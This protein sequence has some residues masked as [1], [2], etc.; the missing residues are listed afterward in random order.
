[1]GYKLFR[2]RS[3]QLSGNP[4]AWSELM[5]WAEFHHSSIINATLACYLHKKDTI[6]DITSKYL[7]QL[8]LHYR[9]D[10]SLPI[11][12]KFELRGAH[13]SSKDAPDTAPLYKMVFDTRPGAVAMAKR[14]IG[15]RL[16]WGT[17]AYLL[18]VRFRPHQLVFGTDGIPFWK[19]FGIDRLHAN[20]HPACRN[21][22]D[23]LEENLMEGRKMKFCCG[24]LEGLPT[25]CC[26]WAPTEAE[27]RLPTMQSESTRASDIPSQVSAGSKRLR[28]NDTSQK[29][30]APKRPK[31]EPG[32]STP[33]LRRDDN[34]AFWYDDTFWC[35]DGDV[36]VRVPGEWTLFKLHRSRLQSQC[37]YFNALFDAQD[38]KVA[39]FFQECPMY[40]TPL[41]VTAK[42]FK[43]LLKAI[44]D[45][46][47]VFES[48]LSRSQTVAL[49]ETAHT[50]SCNSVARQAANRLRDLWDSSR[51]PTKAGPEDDRSYTTTITTI[52]LAREYEI[53]EVLKRAF[54]ELLSSKDYWA[55]YRTDR[56]SIE[57][58]DR[59]KERLAYG[60]A[61]LSEVWVEFILEVPEAGAVR[62]LSDERC[63][64]GYSERGPNW[65]SAI[66]ERGDLR[67]GA[68]DPLRY[69]VVE[70]NRGYLKG[71]GWCEGCLRNKED[72]WEAKRTEWWGLLDELFG[73]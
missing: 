21:P 67:L 47:E 70:R 48:M 24:K 63:C 18:M 56:A 45:P 72:A 9:D 1:M 20:A 17:G 10:P 49:L 57:L 58:S 53:P 43:D 50:L 19:H 55:A 12:T 34:D 22:L 30:N 61:I 2:D 66:V 5:Q 52:R 28:D 29:N 73:L 35:H 16:Y 33:T 8:S 36:V 13:F 11:E 46:H 26:V 15:E 25:C 41:E 23:Q 59:D 42:A 31:S 38:V 60:R 39:G 4:N 27:R 37:S 44:E 64:Y 68:M 62:R 69:N 65:R 51:I 54:Y 7:L 14:D 40:D 6:P 3:V 71:E 32:L